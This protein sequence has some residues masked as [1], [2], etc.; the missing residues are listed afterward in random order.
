M[1]V[2]RWLTV[3]NNTD[4]IPDIPSHQGKHFGSYNAPSISSSGLVVFRARS[5][6]GNER[7]LQSGEGHGPSTGIFVRDM[8]DVEGSRIIRQAGRR[9]TVPPP[10]NLG[11]D[12]TEFPSFP[13]VSLA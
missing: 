13:R 4:V 6:G 7:K 9:A 1:F 12:F 3:V 2:G 5:K 8:S 10:N 11:T